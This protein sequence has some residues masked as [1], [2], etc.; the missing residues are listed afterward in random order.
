MT[1]YGPKV[2]P[3]VW[4]SRIAGWA[5]TRFRRL[6]SRV[7]PAPLAV[8]D[9]ANGWLPT[10]AIY[11]AAALGIA[12]M[13]EDGPLSAEEIA[14]RADADP[15][16][17]YRLLRALSGYGI[18]TH[19]ASDRFALNAMAEPLRT[20]SRQTVRPLVLASGDPVLWATHGQLLG[21]VR[22]GRSGHELAHGTTGF[23]HLEAAPELAAKFHETMRVTTAMSV[24]PLLT[25]Y[26]FGQFGRIVDVGGG[27]GE[28]VAAILRAHPGLRGTVFD[29]ASATGRASETFRRAGVSDR[30]AIENGSFFDAVPPGADAYLLKN[31]IHDWPDETAVEILRSVRCAL[32]PSGRLLLIECVVPSDR[33]RPH[34]SHWLDLQVMLTIGGR[35]RTRDEYAEL[36]AQAQFRIDRIVPT[37][38][39]LSVVEAV[40]I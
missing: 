25:V 15:G 34:F 7:V 30:G 31:I 24:R 28:L 37:I 21:A 11:V 14:R 8:L 33:N 16:S 29:L 3:P 35:E 12:E 5:Y 13:L 23:R 20:A 38:T 4:I 1:R 22:T 6:L 39:P 19:L 36:L 10:Q 17:T 2:L 26:D 32:R 27:S 40:P 9:L 18:F